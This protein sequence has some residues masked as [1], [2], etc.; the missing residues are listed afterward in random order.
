MSIKNLPM[1]LAI[2][3]TSFKRKC[4]L[5]WAILEFVRAYIDDLLVTTMS[6][7]EDHLKCLE[8][9]FQRL[10]RCR[11]KSQCKEILSLDEPN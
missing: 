10:S 6:N 2:V 11:I 4:Q 7:W 3:Q 9:V 1:G 8:M 5:Y